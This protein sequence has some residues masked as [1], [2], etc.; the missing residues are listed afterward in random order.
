MSGPDVFSG[1]LMRATLLLL[2]CLSS[3][4]GLGACSLY[5]GE[6]EPVDAPRDIWWPGGGDDPWGPACNPLA[7]PGQQ[8]CLAGQKCTWIAVQET[9]EPLGKLGCVPDGTVELEG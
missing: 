5:F 8:R 3:L 6:D 2:S 7:P 1:G 4:A 9:P